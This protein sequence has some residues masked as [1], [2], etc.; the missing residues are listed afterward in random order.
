MIAKGATKQLPAFTPPA[1]VQSNYY[2]RT[3][4]II[5]LNPDEAYFNLYSNEADNKNIWQHHVPVQY[6]FLV[7]KLKEKIICWKA[8][9]FSF[10][11]V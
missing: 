8:Q 4:N 2:V 7:E 5:V 6:F 3:G 11:L 1:Y 10:I 9:A